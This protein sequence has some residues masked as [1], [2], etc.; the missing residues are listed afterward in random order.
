MKSTYIEAITDRLEINIE[1][2]TD[3]AE[4]TFSHKLC[5]VGSLNSVGGHG[6]KRGVEKA[7]PSPDF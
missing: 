1:A 3:R 7:R 4:K 5:F 2:I 6:G